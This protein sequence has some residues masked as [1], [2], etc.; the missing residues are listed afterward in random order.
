MIIQWYPVPDIRISNHQKACFGNRITLYMDAFI[1][2]LFK[3]QIL[4]HIVIMIQ[5]MDT[6]LLETQ[7]PDDLLRLPGTQY[8]SGFG[9]LDIEFALTFGVRILGYH[10]TS[11]LL[12]KIQ[13]SNLLGD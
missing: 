2:G 11:L 13:T 6:H 7:Y 4:K 9:C 8:V 10:C 1:S 3:V 5:Y 12:F